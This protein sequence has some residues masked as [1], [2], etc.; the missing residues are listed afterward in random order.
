M[1]PLTIHAN[2]IPKLLVGVLY[3][4]K[5]MT[6]N[7]VKILVVINCLNEV[8]SNV[9]VG[10]IFRILESWNVKYTCPKRTINGCVLKYGFH[11]PC[12]CDKREK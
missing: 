9:F 5:I 2:A 6:E 12:N 8:T 10:N 11:E 1:H 4:R 7:A 3:F